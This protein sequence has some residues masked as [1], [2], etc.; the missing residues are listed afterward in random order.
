MTP[1]SVLES[2]YRALLRLLPRGYRTVREDEIVDTF[3]VGMRD[4]DPENFDLTLKHGRPSGPEARAVVALA[5]RA[6]WGETVA[7]ERFAV[8]RAGL[9]SA[10]M[11]ALTM[12]WTVAVADVCWLAWALAQPR[13]TGGIDIWAATFGLPAGTWQWFQQWSQVAW[14]PT[15]PLLVFG[16]RAGARWAAACVALP[17]IAGASNAVRV[18]GVAGPVW[19]G[20]LAPVLIDLAVAVGL[21]AVGFARSEGATRRPVRYLVA[22]C[23]AILALNV[24]P[25]LLALGALDLPIEGASYSLWTSSTVVLFTDEPALWC[26]ASVIAALWLVARR[27][28][29]G[30]ISAANLLALSVFAGAA[31]LYRLLSAFGAW[32][33]AMDGF[34]EWWNAAVATQFVLA[35]AI[36][37]ISGV[38]AARRLHRLPPPAYLPDLR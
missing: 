27:R 1:P 29:G 12:L 7:P 6:R 18:I 36:C 14:L 23:V 32:P 20:Y 17:L 13:M 37:V 16:G 21:L 2:R 3:L 22:A 15:L 33:L 38:M 5:L 9:R 8:R 10:V 4:A 26:W 25:A 11:M 35:A 28:H 34:G 24:L 19:P 31:L 30:A